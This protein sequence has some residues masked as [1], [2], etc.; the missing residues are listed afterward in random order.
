MVLNALQLQVQTRHDVQ[1]IV[2]GLYVP[3]GSR[4]GVCRCEHSVRKVAA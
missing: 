4:G 3:V 1:S 2:T